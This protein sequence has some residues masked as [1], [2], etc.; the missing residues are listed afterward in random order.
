M[1][2]VDSSVAMGW[3]STG[4]STS[5][6]AE[7]TISSSLGGA[8]ESSGVKSSLGGAGESSRVESSSL[9]KREQLVGE[10]CMRVYVA[11]ILLLQ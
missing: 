5:S 6:V 2:G 4:L 11:Y 1:G 9:L 3:V 7:W 8:G 10:N